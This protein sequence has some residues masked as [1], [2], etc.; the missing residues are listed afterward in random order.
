MVTDDELAATLPDVQTDP[1]ERM[2]LWTPEREVL[3]GIYD[4]L[5]NILAAQIATGGGKPP[6][7]KPYPRP[8]TAFHRARDRSIQEQHESLAKRLTGG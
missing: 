1:V 5:V 3:A 8:M 6:E 7:M 4:L 2:S